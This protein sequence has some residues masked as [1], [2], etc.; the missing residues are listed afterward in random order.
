VSLQRSYDNGL[1]WHT[2][3]TYTTATEDAGFE[4]EEGVCY[5]LTILTGNFIS[6]S[7]SARISQ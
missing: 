1:S 3:S 6:G 4:P 2:V 5:M 7:V